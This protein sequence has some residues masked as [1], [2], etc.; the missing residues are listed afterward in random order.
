ME[1]NYGTV[2]ELPA[3][4][5]ELIKN[6]ATNI[7]NQD[8]SYFVDNFKID[9]NMSLYN[10]NLNGFGAELTFCRL[11]GVEFDSSY[12]KTENHFNNADAILWNGLTV[13]VKTTTY[14]SGKL[15]IRPGKEDSKV[16][17]YALMIGTFPMFRFAGWIEY[18]NIIND[19]LLVD[20]GWGPGYC[21]PQHELNKTLKYI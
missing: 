5:Q 20:L 17:L 14:Q 10:M 13:D 4:D 8:R 12:D 19:K 15:L 18:E 2:Y 7:C 11:C 21:L 3:E 16:D 9:K 6:M 1:L